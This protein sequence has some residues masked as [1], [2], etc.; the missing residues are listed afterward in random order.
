M[1]SA[2]GCI[3]TRHAARINNSRIN[4]FITARRPRNAIGRNFRKLDSVDYY[5]TR[6]GYSHLDRI[7][8]F[9]RREE[10]V[11]VVGY[12]LSRDLSF[13]LA[14]RARRESLT[15]EIIRNHGKR[16]RGLARDITQAGVY[17]FSHYSPP[18]G[19]V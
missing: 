18:P 3:V 10:G 1:Q 9:Y 6:P 19:R 15:S 8:L 14:A 4:L 13:N 11:E 16:N 2:F 5:V 12:N 17:F 7:V